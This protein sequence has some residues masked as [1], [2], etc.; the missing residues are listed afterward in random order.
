MSKT[1]Y[2]FDNNGIYL[3]P[4]EADESPL[5]PGVYLYPKNTTSVEPPDCEY[6][7][8]PIWN[9]K[10]WI[11]ESIQEPHP[12]DILVDFLCLYPNVYEYIKEKVEEKAK[13]TNKY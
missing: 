4:T 3:H 6:N 10:K 9:G 7:E 13:N 2:Q 5:E 1:V 11:I 8:I 12:V